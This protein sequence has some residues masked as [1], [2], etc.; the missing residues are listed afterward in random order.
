MQLMQRVEQCGSDSSAQIR[1]I[2]DEPAD[3]DRPG[4]C[5][6]RNRAEHSP[7][8]PE[9]QKSFPRALQFLEGLTEWREIR[10]A[11][12][13]RFQCICGLGERVNLRRSTI[14]MNID[15]GD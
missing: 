3:R 8:L 1:G 7:V 4:N 15:F 13:L 10:A 5:S 14:I 2:H 6:E 12:P 9:N 11:N